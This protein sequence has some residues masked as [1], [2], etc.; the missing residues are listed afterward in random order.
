[1]IILQDGQRYTE[2]KYQLEADFEKE[3]ADS[4]KAIFGK[5]TIYIDAKRK[6]GQYWTPYLF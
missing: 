6:I 1:M 5:D 3:I 4:Q 2:F